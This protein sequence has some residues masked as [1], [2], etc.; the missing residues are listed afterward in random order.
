MM[1]LT[2]ILRYNSKLVSRNLS[3]PISI[4]SPMQVYDFLKL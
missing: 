1:D 2:L 3:S 4:F